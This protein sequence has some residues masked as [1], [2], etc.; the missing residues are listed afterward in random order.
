[1]GIFDIVRYGEG[2]VSGDK[3]RVFDN[4]NLSGS[5]ATHII[6]TLL[7]L[8]LPG[9]I[10]L[11]RIWL[12]MS[13][14][15]THYGSRDNVLLIVTIVINA[16]VLF[17]HFILVGWM[18]KGLSMGFNG[19]TLVLTIMFFT[20]MLFD[21]NNLAVDHSG[22]LRGLMSSKSEDWEPLWLSVYPSSIV[23]SSVYFR[24]LW[25]TLLLA[26]ITNALLVFVN[27]ITANRAR[28]AFASNSKTPL[29]DV[30]CFE[31]RHGRSWVFV[32]VFVFTVVQVL[33][34]VQAPP[35]ATSYIG[36][37]VWAVFTF[38]NGFAVFLLRGIIESRLTM[39]DFEKELMAHNK[40]CGEY[41]LKEGVA[42]SV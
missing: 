32:G 4:K 42:Q 35:V 25:S 13:E 28:L 1:M 30:R 39:V 18:S 5:I 24:I 16:F 33:A 27:I 40:A 14:A 2:K 21:F 7:L 37:Y 12:D 11:G 31:L 36:I 19:I 34:A 6:L 3:F 29:N 22:P 23:Y 10:L 9:C 15:S 26:L 20:Y 17:R 41:A 38:A 8:T